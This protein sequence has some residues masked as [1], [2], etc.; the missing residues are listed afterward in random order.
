[1]SFYYS[2]FPA[3]SWQNPARIDIQWLRLQHVNPGMAGNDE[4][5]HNSNAFLKDVAVEETTNIVFLPGVQR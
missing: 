3:K 1:M 5:Q 2:S 4:L